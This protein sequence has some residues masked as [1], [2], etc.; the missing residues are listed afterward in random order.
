MKFFVANT[1]NNWYGIDNI[2]NRLFICDDTVPNDADWHGIVNTRNSIIEILLV[3]ILYSMMDIGTA[4][5][6]QE[7]YVLLLTILCP[8]KV[9]F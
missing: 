8:T 9:N 6:T 5:S 1:Y 3:T 4:S 2:R 7:N